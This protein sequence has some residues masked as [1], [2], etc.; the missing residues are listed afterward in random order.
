MKPDQIPLT[1]FDFLTLQEISRTYNCDINFLKDHCEDHNIMFTEE[2]DDDIY[3]LDIVKLIL[4]FK[5]S[6][7]T[8]LKR[9]VTEKCNITEDQYKRLQFG[10]KYS[11][12]KHLKMESYSSEKRK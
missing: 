6:D 11:D 7:L 5:I 2:Q 8:D 1:C 3:E 12:F 9:E 10:A 4:T